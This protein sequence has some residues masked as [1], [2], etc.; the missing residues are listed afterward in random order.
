[1]EIGGRSLYADG[2]AHISGD[3]LVLDGP[4]ASPDVEQGSRLDAMRGDRLD[5]QARRF[6][7]A[8]LLIPPQLPRGDFGVEKGFNSL[9]LTAR[10]R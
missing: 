4:D 10:H 2:A 3:Q 9:A 1:M 8:S 5:Q 6:P 7:G